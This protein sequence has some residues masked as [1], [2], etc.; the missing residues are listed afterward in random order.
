MDKNNTTQG[1]K[2]CYIMLLFLLFFFMFLF[3]FLDDH[4]VC[5]RS[6][7]VEILFQLPLF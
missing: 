6:D 2:L 3:V 4:S 1:Q 7:D 5:L